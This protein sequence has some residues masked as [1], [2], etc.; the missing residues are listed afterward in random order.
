MSAMSEEEEK[1]A[2]ALLGDEKD[3]TVAVL[4]EEGMTGA[5]L[6]GE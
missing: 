3:V 4:E 2:G 6:G 5:V 1:G